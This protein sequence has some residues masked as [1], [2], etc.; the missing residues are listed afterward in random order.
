MT[1]SLGKAQIARVMGVSVR[2]VERWLS[3][4]CPHTK[5]KGKILFAEHEVRR[6]QQGE[7][8]TGRTGRPSHEDAL[9]EA[10]PPHAQQVPGSAPVA[11]KQSLARAELARKISIAKKN[12]L[13]VAAEKALK[14]LGLDQKI[15]AAG[16]HE[17][18]FRLNQEVAALI[19][20]GVLLPGRGQA[21]QRVLAEARQNL[22]AQREDEGP[23]SDP[24]RS[25]LCTEDAATLARVFDCIV[26]DQHRQAVLQFAHE[27]AADD[28]RD[29]P[30]RGEVGV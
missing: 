13:E 16:T 6:W 24:E 26:S 28:L 18:L 29:H 4:G 2:T 23:S 17:D 19:A 10:A 9:P 15:R 5:S 21:L 30:D 1:H 25:F 22:R 11:S 8:L 27:R 14:D 3:R 12:E 20:S 7:A